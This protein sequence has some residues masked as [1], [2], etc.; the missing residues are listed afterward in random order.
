MPFFVHSCGDY[1]TVISAKDGIINFLGGVAQRLR[2]AL[3]KRAGA[4]PRRFE[5]CLLRRSIRVLPDSFTIPK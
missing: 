2:H 5:S 3:G 4:I 1:S